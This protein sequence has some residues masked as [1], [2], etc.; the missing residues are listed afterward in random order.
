VEFD[1]AV[2]YVK[3]VKVHLCDCPRLK[4]IC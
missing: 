2:R 3:K 1:S 4:N